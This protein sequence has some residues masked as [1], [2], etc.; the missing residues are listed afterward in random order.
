M[1]Y[2]TEALLAEY[3]KSIQGLT[4][5]VQVKDFNVVGFILDNVLFQCIYIKKKTI[6]Y[7]K[8]H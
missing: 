5:V 4:F 3:G 1:V 8:Y 6:Y 7:Q 2:A